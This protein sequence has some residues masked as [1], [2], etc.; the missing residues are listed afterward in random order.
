MGFYLE[1]SLKINIFLK[2]HLIRK[3]KIYCKK[4][5]EPYKNVKKSHPVV[6]LGKKSHDP[7]VLG[8]K[9]SHDPVVFWVKKS[10]DPVVLLSE[11][12]HDPLQFCPTPFPNKF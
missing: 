11:K 3:Y 7:V 4:K 9:K 1:L 5:S 8:V 10:H 6:L 2:K 12:S